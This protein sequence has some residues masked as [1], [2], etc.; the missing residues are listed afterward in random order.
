LEIKKKLINS[1]IWSVALY[2]SETWILGENED[3]VI[4]AFEMWWQRR[5][6]KINWTDRIT[7]DER[8][9]IFKHFKR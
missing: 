4:N 9:I 1:C 8:K 5:M 7:N 3:R 6:L 2:G